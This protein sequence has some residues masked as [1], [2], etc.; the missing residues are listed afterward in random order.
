MASKIVLRLLLLFA[1]L[2][3]ANFGGYAYAFLARTISGNPF[4]AQEAQ[5]NALW[6]DYVRY[7]QGMLQGGYSGVAV[8]E[9]DFLLVLGRAAVASAGLLGLALVISVALGLAIGLLGVRLHPPG[10]RGWLTGT[11][12]FGLATPS[13]FI[14]RLAVALLLLATIYLGLGALP[15][16]IQGF[17]WDN[18]LVLPL[19][20]LCVRPT[21]Q[22][23]QVVAGLLAGE[24]GRQYVVAARGKGLTE[25]RVIRH[26]ALRNVWA[27]TAHAVA[28]SVRLLV[29]ELIVV[30]WLFAWPGLGFLMAATL[31]PAQFASATVAA[32]YLDPPLVASLL[33]IFAAIFLLTDMVAGIVA[34]L[35][36]PRQRV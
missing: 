29:A 4:F 17:G 13:F 14:G 18:H 5:T 9:E 36:D 6:P 10:I 21:A 22:I 32:R 11:T 28:G 8:Y 27:P 19:I 15:L 31:I 23:A 33:T 26:H 20:A 25:N 1:L 7:V 12:I 16:P 35:A 2:A 24:L 34:R 30:E 3:A